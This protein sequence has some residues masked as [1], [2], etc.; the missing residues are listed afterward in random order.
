MYSISKWHV[1][2]QEKIV[3]QHLPVTLGV[4]DISYLVKVCVERVLYT[5]SLKAQC[6]TLKLYFS[7]LVLMLSVKW[8]LIPLCSVTAKVRCRCIFQ[9]FNRS[10]MPSHWVCVCAHSTHVL[11][12]SVW[13][14][15]CV[16][17]L[18]G[19]EM[20]IWGHT[21]GLVWQWARVI[22][23][24]Q[25]DAVLFLPR[26]RCLSGPVSSHLDGWASLLRALTH[27]PSAPKTNWPTTLLQATA[28][29]ANV[30]DK[31]ALRERDSQRERVHL[32]WFTNQT[33]NSDLHFS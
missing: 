6:N 23:R 21:S 18:S 25:W 27:L 5:C 33:F 14:C 11:S 26:V 15:V 13:E 29:S 8:N 22:I 19:C 24:S 20:A 10:D 12:G 30:Q 1:W 4:N 32:D 16:Q 2:W 7:P 28:T 31:S 9:I 3:C 17:Q